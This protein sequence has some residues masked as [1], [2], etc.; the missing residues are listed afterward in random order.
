[1]KKPRDPEPSSG[2]GLEGAGLRKNSSCFSNIKIFLISECALM[3]AQ[4]TVGAY[5]VSATT[6]GL[7]SVVS[8]RPWRSEAG[9]GRCMWRFESGA[10]RQREASFLVVQSLRDSTLIPL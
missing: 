5:L 3:L 4:G 7:L 10:G 9:L 2:D 8:P 6:S 1:M